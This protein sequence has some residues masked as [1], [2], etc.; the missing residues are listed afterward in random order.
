M[1]GADMVLALFPRYCITTSIWQ[2]YL[3][4][5][6][7][8]PNYFPCNVVSS[9][10]SENRSPLVEYILID[11][12]NY[13][14]KWMNTGLP[15]IISHGT[16]CSLLELWWADITFSVSEMWSFGCPVVQRDSTGSSH[17][18]TLYCMHSHMVITTLCGV[19]VGAQLSCS[20]WGSW[21][22]A[23]PNQGRILIQP[24]LNW[25]QIHAALR[26]WQRWHR[27]WLV[28]KQHHAITWTNVNSSPIKSRGQ[29]NKMYSRDIFRGSITIFCLDINY[30]QSH[31]SLPGTIDLMRVR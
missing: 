11:Y 1:G 7:W 8:V 20:S 3:P 22:I 26:P 16:V 14:F 25:T 28:T 9:A 6:W 12:E 23:V 27:Q 17:A 31:P 29:F 24:S 19:Y 2:K 5:S 30:L 15:C 4:M 13:F 10:C 21:N 18:I